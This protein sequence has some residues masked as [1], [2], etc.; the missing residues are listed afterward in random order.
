MS[1]Y[2]PG[3]FQFAENIMDS[4]V[5]SAR[6]RAEI[7]R[8]GRKASLGRAK[9]QRFYSGALALLGQRLTFWGKSLQERHGAE[10]TTSVS[11]SARA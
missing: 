10:G 9:G 7:A 2:S 1:Q 4:S 5:K 8:L 3:T 11:Q 6:R